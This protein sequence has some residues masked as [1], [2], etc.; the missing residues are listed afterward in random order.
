MAVLQL[1]L[2]G[3]PLLE[4]LIS[5]DATSNA[6]AVLGGIASEGAT[7]GRTRTLRRMTRTRRPRH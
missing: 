4:H 6:S 7:G 2:E 3:P 5:L 1:Q